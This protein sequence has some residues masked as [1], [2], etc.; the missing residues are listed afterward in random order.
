MY[1]IALQMLFGDRGKYLGIIIGIAMSSIIIIQQPSI[2]V[3]MLSHTYS[4]ITDI[5]LPDIWV[6]DPKVRTSEDS[7]ALLDTQLYRVRGIEGVEW[8]V[9]LYKGSLTVR[10]ENGEL[11]RAV[12][13]GLDDATLI[14]GPGTMV[15]GKLSDLR[16][17]DAVIVDQAGANGRLAKQM[18]RPGEPGIPLRVGDT[19]EIDEK[20]A[21]VVGIAKGTP[22]F[23]SDPVLYTTY[24]KAKNYASSER[25]LLSFILAKAKPDQSPEA[26]A[27]R[28][29]K[30][31]DLA[32]YTAG[33]FKKRSLDFMLHNSSMLINFGFVVLVG[34]VVGTAVTGQIFY[35]FTLDNL[36]YFGVFKAMGATD[37]TLLGM[38]LLQAL[39]AGLLGFGLGSGLTAAFAASTW[40]NNDIKLE[41]GLPL[42]GAS[43]LAVLLIVL[44]AAFFSARKVL[45]LEP[46]EVFKS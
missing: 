34:F 27:R 4:L 40:S 22:T 16:M 18:G 35:N 46:A 28:I 20:R 45:R 11:E 14:G 19:L 41:V 12:M 36:R 25:K 24:S 39:L 43:G 29:A 3:T 5:S 2:L 8:A 26:V 30:A 1:R 21:T 17:P 31:T 13:L 32:A 44:A 10:L 42:L 33:E 37:R 7:R 23:H 15:E 9:P 38:I 6:M